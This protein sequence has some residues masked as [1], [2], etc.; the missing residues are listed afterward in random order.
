MCNRLIPLLLLLS[1]FFIGSELYASPN[2]LAYVEH[3]IQLKGVGQFSIWF[4]VGY[5]LF[6]SLRMLNRFREVIDLY[7][8][9]IP[10]LLGAYAAV[11]YALY[12]FGVIDSQK[13]LSGL[14][15]LFLFYGILNDIPVIVSIFS[16]FHLVV[17]VDAVIY[18][19]LII[20]YIQL[21]HKV[22]LK[23]AE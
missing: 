11:P 12:V 8:P 14:F 3:Q 15:N 20:H 10:Y 19:F 22:R 1:C 17:F 9:F 13:A 16:Q 23:Y 18:L 5:I 2:D 4:I 6:L 21:V 7:G